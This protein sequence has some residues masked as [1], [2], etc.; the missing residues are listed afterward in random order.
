MEPLAVSLNKLQGENI[1]FLG[2]YIA[3]TILVLTTQEIINNIYKYEAL[4]A[5]EPNN[6]KCHTNKILLI[7]LIK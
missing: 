4:S 7:Y 5:I 6:C 1:S 2:G 3:P